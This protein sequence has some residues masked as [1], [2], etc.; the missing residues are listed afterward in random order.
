MTGLEIEELCADSSSF[1]AGH[2]LEDD[3]SVL[4]HYK[5]GARGLLHF[6]QTATGERNGLVLCVYGDKKSLT[7]AQETPEFLEVR[8]LNRMSSILHKGGPY[9]CDKAR[10]AARLALGHPEGL[11]EA[12]ANLYLSFFESIR[13]QTR[14]TGSERED[15]PNVDDGVIGMC[16]V[17]TVLESS[18]SDKKWIQMK[19]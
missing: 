9:L 11:V 17:E 19:V 13:D 7:W 5:G 15:F 10:A 18:R 3:A 2:G 4:V 16:F 1:L 6:S 8:D 12:F 14:D